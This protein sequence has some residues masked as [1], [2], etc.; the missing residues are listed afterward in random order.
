M[1]KIAS[2]PVVFLSSAEETTVSPVLR[3]ALQFM[4]IFRPYVTLTRSFDCRNTRRALAG[5][6]LEPIRVT[7]CLRRLLGYAVG[8]SWGQRGRNAA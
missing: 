2:Q 8:N 1:S 4:E 7:D 6:A 3:R 5:R